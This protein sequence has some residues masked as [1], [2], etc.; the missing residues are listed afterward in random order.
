VV[1]RDKGDLE[2]APVNM[3]PGTPKAYLKL[4]DKAMHR[5]GVG[6]AHDMKSVITRIFLQSSKFRVHTAGES[7]CGGDESLLGP[8]GCGTS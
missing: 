5:L 3:T 4:P 7:P 6:T 8:S 2:A 1:S